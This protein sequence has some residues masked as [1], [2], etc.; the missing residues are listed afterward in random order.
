MTT[1]NSITIADGIGELIPKK[2]PL[3]L[4]DFSDNTQIYE[5]CLTMMQWAREMDNIQR[6]LNSRTSNEEQ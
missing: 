1:I 6:E 4:K 5:S 3:T 2:G